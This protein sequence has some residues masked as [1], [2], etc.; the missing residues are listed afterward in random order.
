MMTAMW[1]IVAVVMTN[2]GPATV[3]QGAFPTETICLEA[4][5]LGDDKVKESNLPFESK[6][7]MFGGG[8]V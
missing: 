7:I 8:S 6:C 4:K 3:M 1:F 5:K 2:Q